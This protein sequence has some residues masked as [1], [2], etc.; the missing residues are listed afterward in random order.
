MEEVGAGSNCHILGNL[1][2]AQE[3]VLEVEGLLGEGLRYVG[4]VLHTAGE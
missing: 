4:M 3:D 2:V 1:E